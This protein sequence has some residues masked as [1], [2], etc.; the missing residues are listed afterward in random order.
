M[1]LVRIRLDSETGRLS[2]AGPPLIRSGKPS[3]EELRLACEGMGIQTSDVL[4]SSWLENGP[5]WLGLLLKD[6][7]AVLRVKESSTSLAG[8]I[9]IVGPYRKA[10]DQV[11][12]KLN[13]KGTFEAT[14]EEPEDASFEVRGF[15]L[16]TEERM[17]DP[18]T[19]R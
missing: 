13:Y 14:S 11:Y 9:G 17:E 4:A 19:G 3:D 18:V 7:N 2:F 12:E 8:F 10:A 1:G 5:P 15:V 16:S 6:A